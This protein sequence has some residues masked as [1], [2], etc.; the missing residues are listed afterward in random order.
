MSGAFIMGACF[1]YFLIISLL[2]A[3]MIYDAIQKYS[4]PTEGHK[5]MAISFLIISPL[6]LGPFPLIIVGVF[7]AAAIQTGLQKE[8]KGK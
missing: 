8:K 7:A 4:W 5:F 2:G 6:V 1:A 3:F